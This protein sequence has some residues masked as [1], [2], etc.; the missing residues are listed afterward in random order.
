M[1]KITLLAS[2]LLFVAAAC[3]KDPN[4][5]E[6]DPD[7]GKIPEVLPTPGVV[8]S[9][10]F[11]EFDCK[12]K[13]IELYNTTGAAIDMTGWTL[14]KDGDAWV[15]PASRG[16]IPAKGF[17]VFTGKSDG[18]TDPTFGLSGTKGFILIL[19]DATGQEIDKMDN[20]A[21]R[22]GGIEQI[23]D[24]ESWGRSDDGGIEWVHFSSPTIGASNSGAAV[25]EIKLFINEVFP[26]EKKLEIYNA[27]TVAVDIA[28]YVFTKD[29]D[30]SSAW[31]V[32]AGMGAIEAGGFIVYTCKQEDAANG[33]TFGLSPTKGFI[34]EMANGS[35]LID[36]V[37]NHKGD[38]NPDF[39]SFA[40]TETYGR[41]TDGASEWVIFS[42]GSIGASN[43]KGTIKQ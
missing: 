21:A 34:I 39:K 25:P 20:S 6:I 33:P 17:A 30:A 35:E 38:D 22:S 19:T 9:V 13:K 1:R 2:A 31:T 28:G 15:I 42:E 14:S 23:P 32:P 43:G 27:S 3:V 8:G 11:N 36:K 37:D 10:V 26:G 40:D 18:T 41:K 12:E 5:K 4:Y 16:Q 29:G 7:Y 24:G